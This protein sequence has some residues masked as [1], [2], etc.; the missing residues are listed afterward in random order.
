MICI[1]VH[2]SAELSTCLRLPVHDIMV[3]QKDTHRLPEDAEEEPEYHVAHLLKSVQFMQGNACGRS[4]GRL[5][6][7]EVLLGT[8]YH[9]V[10]ELILKIPRQEHQRYLGKTYISVQWCQPSEKQRK[11]YCIQSGVC[12]SLW[13]TMME[14]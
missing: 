10:L 6:E 3:I 2:I 11:E 4:D 8:A 12:S 9:Y 7:K 1:T 5:E 14:I 13:N